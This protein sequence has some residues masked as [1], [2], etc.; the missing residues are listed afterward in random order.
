MSDYAVLSINPS[1]VFFD[2]RIANSLKKIFTFLTVS[3]IFVGMTGFFQTFAGYILLGGIPNLSLCLAVSLMTFSVYN[4]NKLTDIK[5]DSINAPERMKFLAGKR[6]QMLYVSL[7]AY[8]LSAAIAFLTLPSALPVVF[9]PLAANTLYSSRL[10]P[11]I[12]RLKDIP[13]MKNVTVALSWAFVC[14]LMPG[15]EMNEPVK[16][17]MPVVYFMIARVFINT[18]IFDIRDVDGDRANGIRTLPVIMGERK[19]TFTLLAVNSTLIPWLMAGRG[20]EL[21]AVIMILYGYAFILGF[22]RIRSP[23][24]MELFVDGEWMMACMLFLVI[25]MVFLS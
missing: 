19:T 6:A 22:R 10:I 21:L 23:L 20:S 7:G 5:E 17:V 18:V 24:T 2:E 1:G 15:I 25:K 8:V 16:A 11:S 4:L 14:T 13:V 12:P 9:I 3:S